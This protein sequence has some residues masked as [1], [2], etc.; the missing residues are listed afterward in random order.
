VKVLV[1]YG[2]HLG[3][4]AAMAERIAAVLGD[5]GLDVTVLPAASAGMEDGAAAFDAFVIGGGT[6]AGRW[7][8]DTVAFIRRHAELLVSKPVWLF[9]S[10]PLGST[11]AA[12]AREPVEMSELAPLVKARAHAVFAGAYERDTIDGSELGRL[13]RFVAKRFI[14][15]GDWR[16]WPS[17]EAWA[18]SI[19]VELRPTTIGAL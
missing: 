13:E 6:Y 1:T 2:S 17:I 11:P 10:G 16:D 18:R 4:T 19:A 8:P 7:H 15:E 9:S 5:S 3:S 12:E 14:P